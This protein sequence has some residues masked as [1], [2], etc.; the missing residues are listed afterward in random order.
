M[1]RHRHNCG[2]CEVASGHLARELASLLRRKRK[3]LGLKELQAR[4]YAPAAQAIAALADDEDRD[5]VQRV[6][7]IVPAP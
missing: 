4:S 2:C 6:F 5:I 7:R 3:Q 1:A